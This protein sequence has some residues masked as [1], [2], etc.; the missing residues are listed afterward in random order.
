MVMLGSPRC[1]GIGGLPCSS[2][3]VVASWQT[4]DDTASVVVAERTSFADVVVA[5]LGSSALAY[6][7]PS[8]ASVVGTSNP[9]QLVAVA[10]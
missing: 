6:L 9:G 5:S 4:V 2:G 10:S 1:F 7:H 8:L 3:S